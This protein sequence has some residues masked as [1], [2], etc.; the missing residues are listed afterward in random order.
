M[1]CSSDPA[2][3][4]LAI[5]IYKELFL[6]ERRTELKMPVLRMGIVHKASSSTSN[7]T[8]SSHMNTTELLLL[9]EGQ[10]GTLKP[11]RECA[12]GNIVKIVQKTEW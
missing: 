11:T 6:K 4:S 2:H 7:A 9:P 10:C 5:A 8:S 3:Q 12:H 1:V